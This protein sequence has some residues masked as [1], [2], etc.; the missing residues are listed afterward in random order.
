MNT[1]L[2]LI[3]EEAERISAKK[4]DRR[5][6]NYSVLKNNTRENSTKSIAAAEDYGEHIQSKSSLIKL[7][8]ASR[9][10]NAFTILMSVSHSSF[11]F[12]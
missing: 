7:F 10:Q 12:H 6:F 11:V 5:K 3:S 2:Y 1:W 8:T 9:C 4:K